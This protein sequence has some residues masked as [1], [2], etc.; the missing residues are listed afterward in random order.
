MVWNQAANRRSIRLNEYC[1]PAGTLVPG[2]KQRIIMRG[3]ASR[4]LLLIIEWVMI[5]A[6]AIFIIKAIFGI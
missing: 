3:G 4:W 6:L 5:I 2:T 1:R